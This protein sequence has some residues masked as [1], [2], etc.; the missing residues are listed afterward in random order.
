[1]SIKLFIIFAG[2]SRVNI[3]IHLI[4]HYHI[5]ILI[6]NALVQNSILNMVKLIFHIYY[7]RDKLKLIELKYNASSS[8]ANRSFSD[9]NTA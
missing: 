6:K 5:S 8:D 7:E 9:T 4:D 3:V 1:M 2:D